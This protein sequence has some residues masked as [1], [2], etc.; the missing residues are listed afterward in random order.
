MPRTQS[1]VPANR[2]LAALP[3]KD[4]RRLLA[5]CKAVDLTFGEIL[6]EPGVR[7]RH[8]YFPT[9]S[10]ISLVTPFDGC[11]S[12]G[13]GLVGD[14]ICQLRDS[15]SLHTIT[16]PLVS[17]SNSSP[18]WR[19]CGVQSESPQP[20]EPRDDRMPTHSYRRMGC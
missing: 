6:A 3:S 20:Q 7:I 5:G 8:V 14:A 15:Q 9:D 17:R 2:L 10:F 13:V 18:G 16:A 4:R 11:A 19:P 1:A 12:L